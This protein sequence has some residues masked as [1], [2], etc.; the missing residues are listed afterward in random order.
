MPVVDVNGAFPAS[1]SFMSINPARVIDTRAGETTADG[2]AQ[3]G[4]PSAAGSV[5]TIPIS[6][7]VGPG[8]H[9]RS[10]GGNFTVQGSH[11]RTVPSGPPVNSR[12]PGPSTS[13]VTSA[14]GGT[15]NSPRT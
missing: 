1:S 5:T 2:I 8:G 13:A 15:R 10:A 6:G 7:R 12:P 9:F 3:G 4:G 14:F 11:A